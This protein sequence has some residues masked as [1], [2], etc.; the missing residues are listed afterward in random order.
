MQIFKRKIVALCTFTLLICFANC[1]CTIKREF[2][3]ADNT[4]AS[5][6]FLAQQQV[7]SQLAKYEDAMRRMAYNEIAEL[8]TIDG[9][10]L[11]NSGAPIQGREAI[12]LF[13]GSFSNYT[14]LENVTQAESTEIVGNSARQVGHYSQ[15]V[16]TPANET[17]QVMG[18]FE[19]RW[20]RLRN[21]DWRIV[22]MHT[23]TDS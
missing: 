4:I 20:A 11:H 15:L 14:M 2:T 23:L 21:G 12:R 18:H 6:Q 9:E 3:V 17:V 5:K 13:M 22:Q 16:R 8:F 10:I 1:G 7:L 19:A